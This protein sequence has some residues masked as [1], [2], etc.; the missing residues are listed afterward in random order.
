LL[1]ET[2]YFLDEIAGFTPAE[3]WLWKSGKKSG[4]QLGSLAAQQ[5]TGLASGKL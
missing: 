4:G 5:P 1:T 3:T 2:D